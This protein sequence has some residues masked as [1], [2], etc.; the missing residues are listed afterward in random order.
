MEEGGGEGMG[1]GKKAREDLGSKG[2][3]R[4]RTGEGDRREGREDRGLEGGGGG[5]EGTGPDPPRVRNATG[6]IRKRALGE[7]TTRA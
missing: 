5:R 3:G 2:G 6:E 4:G 7:R 1:G